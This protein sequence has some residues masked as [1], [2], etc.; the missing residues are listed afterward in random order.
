MTLCF[1]SRRTR[2]PAVLRG[3]G[4][5]SAKARSKSSASPS[6]HR[7]AAPRAGAAATPHIRISPRLI[8]AGAGFALVGVVA[9]VLATD[10]RASR[11]G[12]AASDGFLSETAAAG[13]RTDH[14]RLE[15]ASPQAGADILR[16][17]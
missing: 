4:R 12:R 5:G 9:I 13:L 16:A 3:A 11:L 15:G 2:M 8:A 1:G 10:H 14:V 6:K 7:A 17:A